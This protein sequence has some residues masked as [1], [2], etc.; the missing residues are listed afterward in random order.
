MNRF[1]S[2]L[3]TTGK[4]ASENSTVILTAVGVT[5]TLMTAFLTGRASFKAAERIR[6][7]EAHYGTRVDEESGEQVKFVED[8]QRYPLSTDEKVRLVW[9]EYLPAVGTA[10]VTI[11]CIIM[12]NRIGTRRAAGL[13]AAYSTTQEVFTQYQKR[14]AEKMGPRKE[15]ALRDELDQEFA[16]RKAPKNLRDVFV[17][18]MGT[19]LCIDKFSGM[20]FRTNINALKEAELDTNFQ[21]MSEGSASLSDF[22]RNLGIDTTDAGDILGWTSD[23]K[24][25]MQMTSV[26]LNDEPAMVISF[27][28]MP[29]ANF[30]RRH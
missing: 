7:E 11:T 29:K 21:I 19:F 23:S 22:Y 30:D 27:A 25:V 15:Q 28:N 8:P 1:T 9:P 3:R 17:V 18:G 4:V 24:L 13:A 14:V 5:G 16:D 6:D 12:A 20:T 10:L 26:V 2:M